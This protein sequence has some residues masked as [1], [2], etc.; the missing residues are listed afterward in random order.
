MGLERDKKPEIN[1]IGK[2][3]FLDTEVKIYHDPYSD[4]KFAICSWSARN[5][6]SFYTGYVYMDWAGGKMT[7]PEGA[8]I[9]EQTKEDREILPRFI[10]TSEKEVTEE[11][12]KSLET[13]L[14]SEHK[15]RNG[16]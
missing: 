7:Y 5:P 14:S 4:S 9:P 2:I 13:Y 12:V 16:N 6:D 11:L 15:I 3:D 1:L 8:V 10:V